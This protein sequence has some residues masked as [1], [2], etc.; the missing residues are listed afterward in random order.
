MTKESIRIFGLTQKLGKNFIYRHHIQPRCSI[1]RAEKRI[2]SYSTKLYWCHQVN[3]CRSGDCTIKTNVW[4]FGCRRKQKSV[5]F[6]GKFYKIYVNE[7]NSSK[8][9]PAIR[10]RRGEERRGGR[11]TRIQTTSRPD[12]TWPDA[13]TRIGK[14]AQRR[15]KQEWVIDKLLFHAK[16]RIPEHA[17]GKPLVQK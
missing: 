3:F 17:Y 11:L 10:E 9:I 14:A 7:R 1:V 12:H 15:K 8:R 13:L 5:R 2:I 4:L 6:V 16:D